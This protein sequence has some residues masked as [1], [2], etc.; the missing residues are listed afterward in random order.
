MNHRK[1][2]AILPEKKLRTA[3]ILSRVTLHE[4][5]KQEFEE[6]K[7]NT[8]NRIENNEKNSKVNKLLIEFKLLEHKD[9]IQNNKTSNIMDSH[10]N[11]FFTRDKF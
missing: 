10:P 6:Q 5:T 1:N 4:I 3:K 9:K 11:Y 8:N 7:L 2:S